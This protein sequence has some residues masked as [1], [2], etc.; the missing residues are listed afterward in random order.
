MEF[1]VTYTPHVSG[2]ASNHLLS[3]ARPADTCSSPLTAVPHPEFMYA[4]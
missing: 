3:L 4:A 1:R 2:K